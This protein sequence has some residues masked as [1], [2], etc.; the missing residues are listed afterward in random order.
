[1]IGECV[2]AAYA[3]IQ[4]FIGWPEISHALYR[5]IGPALHTAAAGAGWGFVMLLGMGRHAWV[6]RSQADRRLGC[7][8]RR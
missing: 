4:P 5:A 7:D 3:S 1:M 8:R 6:S 2:G